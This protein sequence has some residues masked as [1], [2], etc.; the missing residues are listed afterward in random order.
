MPIYKICM[1]E[2]FLSAVFTRP[3][4]RAG[5]KGWSEEPGSHDTTSFAICSMPFPSAQMIH[6]MHP[7]GITSFHRL[8]HS[9][10]N[11]ILKGSP[12]WIIYIIHGHHSVHISTGELQG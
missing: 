3:F 9:W 7:N 5:W 1:S 10:S 2:Q 6:V 11:L 12:P 4:L 8:F